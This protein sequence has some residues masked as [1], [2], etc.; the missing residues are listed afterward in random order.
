M[1]TEPAA[2]PRRSLFRSCGLAV[3]GVLAVALTSSA[4]FQ[5]LHETLFPGAAPSELSCDEGL[6]RLY[7]SIQRAREQA[8]KQL[9]GERAALADFRAALEPEWSE[10][11]SIRARCRLDSKKQGLDAL[12]LVELLRYAEERAVRYEAL[13]LARLRRTTP[14]ALRAFPP[15][16]HPSR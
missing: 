7:S 8:A 15:S 16:S 12:R 10:A 4:T 1:G 6:N 11:A 9:A 14:E 2:R 13:D 5:I 3:I